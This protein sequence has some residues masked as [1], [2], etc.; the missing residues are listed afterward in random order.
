MV[1]ASS[2]CAKIFFPL[3]LDSPDL[4]IFRILSKTSMQVQV[5]GYPLHYESAN[6]IVSYLCKYVLICNLI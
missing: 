1:R 2:L 4:Y 6:L 3:L 5:I